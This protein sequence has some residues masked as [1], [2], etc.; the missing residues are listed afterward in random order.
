MSK[1]I[2]IFSKEHIDLALA[3]KEKSPQHG[4]ASLPFLL[5]SG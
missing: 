4:Q 2:E 3:V 5:Q 1:V